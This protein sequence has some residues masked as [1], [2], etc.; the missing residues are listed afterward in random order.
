MPKKPFVDFRE[1]RSRIT[2]EQVLEHYGVLD[3]F[4]PKKHAVVMGNL[5]E[6]TTGKIIGKILRVISK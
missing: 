5:T 1:V 2:M 6:K 4:K 3:T